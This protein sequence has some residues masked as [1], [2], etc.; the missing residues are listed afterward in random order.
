MTLRGLVIVSAMVCS[1]RANGQAPQPTFEVASV[2]A[3]SQPYIETAPRRSTGRFTWTTDLPYMI[4]YAYR[5]Q[6]DRLSGP[7]P[8]SD[9]TYQLVATTT[10]DATEDQVRLMLQSLL[11]ERFQM[12]AHLVTK[13]GERY[14]L[15]LAKG[16]PKIKEVKLDEVASE[17][18]G[19]VASTVE[20]AAT[21]K[22]T[23]WKATMQVFAE[24]L[25]RTLGTVV[26]DETGLKGN[27]DFSIRFARPDRDGETDEAPLFATL[28]RDLGLKLEKGKGPVDT[29]VVDRI[30]SKP[31][32]N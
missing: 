1:C 6:R 31:V 15:S 4:A 14:V 3:V 5:L 13:E 25:Q 11:G 19:K 22:I 9:H 23:A 17:K 18:D 30:E 16:G 21:G 12:R 8:G 10:R 26:V 27:Y 7:I 29:L 2:K 24:A 28:Q 20:T 32:E